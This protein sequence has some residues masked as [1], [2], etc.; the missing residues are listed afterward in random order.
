MEPFVGEIKMVGFSFVPQGYAFCDASLMSITQNSALF[1][2]LGTTFGGDGVNTFRL[3]DYRGRTPVGMGNGPSLTPIVQGQLSGSENVSI[4]QTQMPNHSHTVAVPATAGG[5]DL[6]TP[7]TSSFLATVADTVRGG[8]TTT[9]AYTA[10]GTAETTLLPF[11]AGASGGGQPLP[12][13]NPFLGTNFII[14]LSGIYPSR[15]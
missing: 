4:L 1:S 5:A 3:P 2:L 13:R 10:T 7:S 15:P 6:Q 9:G 8:T 14:A 11:N 12:I